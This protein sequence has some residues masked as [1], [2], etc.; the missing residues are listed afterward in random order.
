MDPSTLA[1]VLNQMP[2]DPS[3][4]LLL[5]LVDEETLVAFRDQLVTRLLALAWPNR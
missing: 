5:R 4:L 3:G 1:Y 2:T